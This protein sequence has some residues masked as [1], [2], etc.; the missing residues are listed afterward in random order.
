M[1]YM[2]DDFE[3]EES[4]DDVYQAF[5]L[6]CR[7]LPLADRRDGKENVTRPTKSSILTCMG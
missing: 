6:A 1:N 5:Y 4:Q 2:A 7:R 3:F